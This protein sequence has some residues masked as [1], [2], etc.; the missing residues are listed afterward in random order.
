MSHSGWFFVLY[1]IIASLER[2]TLMNNWNGLDFFIFL[3]FFLNTILGISRGAAKEVIALMCLSVALIIT[4]TFTIPLTDFCNSSPLIQDVISSAIVQNFMHTIGAG[5]LTEKMIQNMN[6]ALSLLI[7][8]VG[9]YSVGLGML[10]F[11][12]FV[13]VFSWPLATLNRQIGAALGCTRG[14]VFTLVFIIMLQHIFIN[15]HLNSFFVNLFQG[16]AEKLQS[17]ID[18]QQP[19]QYQKIYE[20]R[21]LY[22]EKD[23]YHTI[24]N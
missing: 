20:D 12:G 16:S 19:D 9:V 8:F 22:N 21:N 3:I 5:P 23:V 13:E 7:C 2:A 18:R 15:T 17:F 4:I 10:S 6:Y 14:Y 11:T 24:V 1:W